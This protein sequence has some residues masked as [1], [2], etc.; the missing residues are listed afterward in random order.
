VRAGGSQVT[1]SVEI[2]GV[3][4]GR[5]AGDGVAVCTQQ[6]SSAYSMAAGGPIVAPGDGIWVVTPL[7]PHGGCLPPV[8]V[9]SGST[10]RL[11]VEPG[12]AGARVEIDGRPAE[13]PLGV[14]DITLHED[15]AVL[16]RVG[17]EEEHFTGLRRRKILIDSP[18]VM[19]RDDR[20]ALQPRGA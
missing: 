1:T 3:L 20:A 7:A 9:G 15:F 2:D 10:V 5:F 11:N 13:I 17:E 12:F 14:Y 18:R 4:Y 8:V 19:A 16:V 6:G